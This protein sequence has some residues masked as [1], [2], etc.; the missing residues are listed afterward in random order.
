MMF[1]M[2]RVMGGDQDIDEFGGSV[3]HLHGN[4][5]SIETGRK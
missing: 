4:E 3:C 1:W 5:K 2:E